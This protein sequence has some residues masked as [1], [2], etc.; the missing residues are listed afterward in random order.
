MELLPLAHKQ[1]PVTVAEKPSS[2]IEAGRW[3]TGRWFKPRYVY[4]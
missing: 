4:K 3:E 2:L 1:L